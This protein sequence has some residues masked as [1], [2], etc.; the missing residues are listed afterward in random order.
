M[1][2]SHTRTTD[3]PARRFIRRTLWGAAA[4]G[5]VAFAIEGGEFGTSDIYDQRGRR[6]RLRAE[7]DSLR[8]TVDSLQAELNAMKTDDALLE[9][10][11]RER[12]GMVKGSKEVLYRIT[13]SVDTSG[14]SAAGASRDSM[15]PTD[16]SLMAPRG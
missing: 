11:A 8:A 15:V 2:R 13:R 6:V 12:F 16:T 3:T 10:V 9:R 5:T 7:V 1:P 4:A 14:N